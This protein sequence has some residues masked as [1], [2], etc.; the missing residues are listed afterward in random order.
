MHFEGFGRATRSEESDFIDQPTEVEICQWHKCVPWGYA[1]GIFYRGLQ[2][3][4]WGPRIDGTMNESRIGAE[5]SPASGCSPPFGV[6]GSPVY[7]NAHML[8]SGVLTSGPDDWEGGQM[9]CG[10]SRLQPSPKVTQWSSS[11]S[12]S[13]AVSALPV[14]F[15]RRQSVRI[16]ISALA[17][18]LADKSY[19]STIYPLCGDR[20]SVHVHSFSKDS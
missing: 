19:G 15:N 13:T 4:I 6:A 20:N 5:I 3:S 12:R 10:G 7:L 1:I 9:R 11:Y 17:V 16:G 18:V 14:E 8:K 2:I